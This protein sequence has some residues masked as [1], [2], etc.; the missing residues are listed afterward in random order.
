MNS[1][2]K[3]V[4]QV[5]LDNEK[6]TLNQ[7]KANYADALDEIENRIAIL[8]ARDDVDLQHVIYQV[9]YQKALKTQVQTVLDQLQ[10]NNFETVSEYLTKSYEDGFIGTMYDMQGQ[11]IPLVFPIDQKQ[12][13]EAL[14]HETKLSEGLYA[15]LGKDTK[16]LSKQISGEISRGISNA[17]MFSEISRNIAGYCGISKNNA[18]RI[19]RTEAHRIQCK[20]TVDAQWKA[21]A[22]GAD[23]VKQWDASLDGRTRDAHREADGQIR[24]L[25]EDFEVG[26]ERMQAP[27]IGGSAANVCNCRCALLQR[28]R[29]ALGNDYTKWDPKQPELISDSGTTQLVKIEAKNYESFKK[30]YEEASERVREDVQDNVKQRLIRKGVQVDIKEAGKYEKEAIQNLNHL[31]KLLDEYKSTTVS[32]TVVSKSLA[33]TENGSA[34]MLKGK[35]AI[36]VRS[37]AYKKIK[38]SD[39]LGLGDNQH[40]G[41]TYHEFAHSLSQSREKTDPEFWKEIRKIKKEYEGMRG[42]NNWFDI[43]ISD[44]ASKDVDE[45]LAEAFAQAKL[46]DNPSQYSKQVLSVVDKYFKKNKLENVGKSSTIK[47][48]ILIHRSVGAKARNYDVISPDSGDVFHFVEG[49][50]IQNSEVFAGKGTKHSLHEGVA[51]G[52]AEQYGGDP[53]K[54]QHCKGNGVIDFDGEERKA[55]VHWFQEETVGKVK[56]KVKRWIDED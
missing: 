12:V 43:K 15:A 45:F 47:S 28:A 14:Q 20:A 1:N 38:A 39:Q 41:V 6:E 22:K 55:E 13:V 7:I 35:T 34:Y 21:K 9:E 53:E 19:A 32:Y 50:K 8:Q 36:S 30:Q 46:S 49:T 31:D 27:G 42:K 37:R 44:Y 29:W 54:W 5:F 10:S 18:M 4:Q 25:D 3:E 2:Q 40:L 56:F 24:E 16:R 11:G 51:E 48:D 26:G 23:V 52:L 33:G 17:A